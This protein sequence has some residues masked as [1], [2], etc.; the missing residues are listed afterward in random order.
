MQFALAWTMNV[1]ADPSSPGT[2]A[3]LHASLGV[4]IA[5]LAFIRLINRMVSP[6]PQSPGIP[7]WQRIAAEAMH[8]ALLAMLILMPLAGIWSAQNERVEFTLFGVIPLAH[9]LTPRTDLARFGHELHEI[10]GTVFLVLIGLHVAAALYH[11]FVQ[12]DDVL[13]RMLPAA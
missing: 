2:L 5:A 12:R 7:A 4:T 1:D 10:G 13:R 9:F 8:W 6:V 3:N 11:H